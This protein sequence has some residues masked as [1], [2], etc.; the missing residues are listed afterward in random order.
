[1]SPAVGDPAGR[2]GKV[3]DDLPAMY[4]IAAVGLYA[5]VAVP[6]SG[7]KDVGRTNTVAF[8][9]RAHARPDEPR[10]ARHEN[11]LARPEGLRGNVL[12]RMW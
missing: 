5:Q 3:D 1:M 7:D 6:R 11:P 12:R 8:E 9:R 10:P 2:C 4:G